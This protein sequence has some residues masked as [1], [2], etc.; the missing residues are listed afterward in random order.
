M[1]LVKNV[2]HLDAMEEAELRRD[3]LGRGDEGRGRVGGTVTST[4]SFIGEATSTT[5]TK[6]WSM[7]SHAGVE[8]AG[9]A[10]GG[11]GLSWQSTKC[12]QC[13]KTASSRESAQKSMKL[14]T[15]AIACW[16]RGLRPG[17]QFL[18]ADHRL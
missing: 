11:N 8:G 7:M 14:I 3:D 2:K 6:R 13:F 17:N 12:G 15:L 4:S 18:K 16:M 9:V 5:C 1:P 10:V